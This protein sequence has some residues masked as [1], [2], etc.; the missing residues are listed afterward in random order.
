[1]AITLA[2]VAREANVSKATASRALNDSP[3]ISAATKRRVRAAVDALGYLAAGPR[4]A[5]VRTQ[6]IAFLIA[7]PSGS[8]HE[9]LF[10]GDVLRGVTDYLEPRGYH[11]IVSP[12][13]GQADPAGQL[14][15]VLQRVEG[16]IA[17]GI[18]LQP[19]LVRA[20]ATGPVPAVFIGRY[21]RGRSANAVLPDNEE[22]GRM[23]TEHL[24]NLGR[25]RIAF[26]GGPLEA[27]AYRDRLAGYHAAHLEAGLEPDDRLVYPTKRSEMGRGGTAA[28]S[29]LLEHAAA[30][31]PMP[32]AVFA[33]DDWIAIDIL[34]ALRVRGLG[35]PSD[36]AVV[37]Y[38]DLPLARVAEPPLTTVHVPR[39]RLGRTAAKLLLELISGEVEGPIQVIVSPHLVV[40]E[41]TVSVTAASSMGEVTGSGAQLANAA[42]AAEQRS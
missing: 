25:R 18:S 38:S 24:L 4:G 1:V 30:G 13:D 35:V 10:F 9:S 22:G 23:A 8:I 42:N 5:T 21:L 2:D 34:R 33:G 20:F 7:D 29:Q 12:N 14:P 40:R 11:A 27:N 36:V 16:L 39:Q 15:S 41:S 6:N 32:D 17:G 19:G 37:G 26:I 3:R 28:L 31:G